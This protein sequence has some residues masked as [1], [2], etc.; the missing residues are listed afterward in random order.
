MVGISDGIVCRILAFLAGNGD[1][2][3]PFVAK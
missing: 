3:M 1:F 2:V